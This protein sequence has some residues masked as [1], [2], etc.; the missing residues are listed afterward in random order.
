M[1]A[2][3]PPIPISQ[4]ILGGTSEFG[5]QDQMWADFPEMEARRSY[6]TFVSSGQN[7]SADIADTI[8][9]GGTPILSYK[10]PV[11]A[12]Q[13]D[14]DTAGFLAGTYDAYLAA[15]VNYI[16]GLN[17]PVTVSFWHEPHNEITPADFVACNHKFIDAFEAASA[18][19]NISHGPI[20][21]GFLLD[22]VADK[23]KFAAFLDS[24]LLPRWDFVAADIY[25]NGT[26]AAPGT[27]MPSRLV[28]NLT[29]MLD[30]LGYPDMPIGV[31]EYNALTADGII[32]AGE[33]FRNEPRLWFA[34][35]W[36][37]VSNSNGVDWT[38]DQARAD[39]FH[40]TMRAE[41]SVE[42]PP[43]GYDGPMTFETSAWA[44]DGALLTSSLARRAE[45]AAVGDAQGV[46]QK[47]DLKVTELDVPGVGLLIAPGVGLIKNDYQ[48]TPSETYVVSN[49]EEHMF[50][51]MPGASVA[52]TS[53]I[54]AIVIGD[55]AFDQ[56]G[57]PWMGSDDPPVGEE[58]TFDYVRPTLIQVANS[59]VTTL[60]V[61]YP[62]LVLARID[63][64]SNATTITN[65]MITDLRKLA[66]P[67][68]SQEI[69]VSPANVWPSSAP[70][71]IPAAQTYGNWGH[72]TWFPT[73]KVPTWANRAIIVASINGVR[74]KDTT[75]NI[76]GSVRMQVGAVS[77]DAVSFDLEADA[78][79]SVKRINL[80]VGGEYDV[81]GIAGTTVNL[82]IEGYQ[83]SPTVPTT[84][85]KLRLQNGSQ[86]IIDVRFFEE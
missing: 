21:N 83:N 33:A 36:I 71:Y 76:T 54:L 50:P 60:D 35:L 46:V 32:E 65:A 10:P 57:H 38:L 13:T 8:A 24:T 23:P 44:I 51:D 73:V 29:E 67:R 41:G 7:K 12:G 6:P 49:I 15:T 64:P 77:G 70:E 20:L 3:T 82:L 63:I 4:K 45:F 16:I 74:V 52:A 53:W 48:D 66:R 28:P 61:A 40:Y 84:N 5:G 80:Q 56:V 68:Q 69:F 86:E 62:A 11:L 14:P 34:L 9:R 25:Q 30:S 81:S 17:V 26:N 79:Q 43:V 72:P 75:V 27:K 31:G 47:N 39:A 18:G 59:S 1:T 2:P 42:P 78:S 58:Q 22:S 85:Q 19:P 37:G 55:P